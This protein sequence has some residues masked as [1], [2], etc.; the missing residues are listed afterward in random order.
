MTSIN[1]G[2]RLS[3]VVFPLPVPPI[4]AVNF[5]GSAVNEMPS[6][7]ECSAPGYLNATPLNSI[8]PVLFVTSIAFSFSEI[9]VSVSK[10]SWIRS[11][12]AAA[13]GIIIDIITAIITFPRICIKYA[14]NA[15]RLPICIEPASTNFPPNQ[16]TATLDEFIIIIRIG[17]IIENVRATLR[18]VPIRSE[19]ANEK[20][21]S[22]SFRFTKALITRTP[23]ICSRRIRLILSN[24]SWLMRKSG[25]MLRNTKVIN[26]ANNGTTT[27]N[28]KE[29]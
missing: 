14:R 21:S 28:N 9:E 8:I 20:R 18:V 22:S 25:T 13:R 16:I 1:R 2:I 11:A 6:R 23:A 5:P 3:S 29:R 15:V 7:T 26:P 10:I 12:L 4:T 19:L 17:N 27:N 24:F